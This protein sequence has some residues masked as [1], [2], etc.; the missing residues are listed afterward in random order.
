MDILFGL[1]V[2]G[3]TQLPTLVVNGIITVEAASTA[4]KQVQS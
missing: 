2:M 4:S 1:N 3:T